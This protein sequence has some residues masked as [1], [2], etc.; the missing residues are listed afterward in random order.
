MGISV[1]GGVLGILSVYPV[2]N[3]LSKIESQIHRK[4]KFETMEKE[5]QDP[6]IFIVLNE[7]QKQVFEENLP[8][9]SKRKKNE[10]QKSSIRKE[11]ES[12]KKISKET[13]YY[14]KEQ[15]KFNEK[16]SEDRSLY[17][18]P[19]NDKEIKQAKKDKVLLSILI[20]EINTKSQSYVEKMQTIVKNKIL[21]C[22][23]LILKCIF[24][25]LTK[26]GELCQILF[27]CLLKRKTKY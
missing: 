9:L 17:D 1:I 15:A 19:L 8:D 18:K 13:L 26:R 21:Y 12:I 3:F 6:K 11:I 20:R 24:V 14:S 23:N 27:I 2:Y 22:E 10:I 7:E 16:Y 25:K 4:R 5:L